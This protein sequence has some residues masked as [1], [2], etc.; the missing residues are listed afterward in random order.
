MTKRFQTSFRH[1]HVDDVLDAVVAVV[2]VVVVVVGRTL[3]MWEV[4]VSM[5]SPSGM[6][7]STLVVL[8]LA[9]VVVGSAVS[10]TA[11]VVA[12]EESIVQYYQTPCLLF[13]VCC[14]CSPSSPCCD[15]VSEFMRDPRCSFFLWTT[16]IVEM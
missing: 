15:R 13:V 3:L 1:A 6:V 9:T 2:A 16:S 11:V 12:C 14:L 5:A 4:V 7:G 8:V 10:W